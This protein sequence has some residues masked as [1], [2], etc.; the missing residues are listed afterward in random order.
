MSAVLP[1][2]GPIF[3]IILLGALLKRGLMPHLGLANGFWDAAERLTYFVLFPAMLLTRTA[4]ASIGE[5]QVVPMAAALTAPILLM[6][7]GLLVVRERIPIDTPGFTSVLQGTIR[8]NI[9][10]A[11]AAAGG[12]YGAAGNTLVAIGV[13]VPFVNVLCVVLLTRL[14]GIADP[15]W[16]TLARALASNPIILSV[17]AGLVLNGLGLGLPPVIGP[18]LDIIGRA[19]LPLGLLC[20]GAG[21][22]F[23]ALKAG[24][25]G[26][27][28]ASVLKLLG[29]PLLASLACLSFG[30]EGVTAQ[31]TILFSAAPAAASSYILARQLG[32][33]HQLMAGILT[34]Q[35]I[36]AAA[37][38]PLI[39]TALL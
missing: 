24:R 12:L 35:V 21:L 1:A 34:V 25:T 11:L 15:G 33:D 26:I 10:V 32:G 14:I 39:V 19:A 16:R 37:T 22:H 2:L 13:V 38:L 7:G 31:V 5:L 30:V 27:V 20:V 6:I 17:C 23:G 18:T 9:Y 36:A 3:L 29:L 28:L 4:T 8:P